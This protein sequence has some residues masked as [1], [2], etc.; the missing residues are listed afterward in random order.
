MRADIVPARRKPV[1]NSQQQGQALMLETRRNQRCAAAWGRSSGK[2]A[3]EPPGGQMSRGRILVARD[4]GRR[5]AIRSS[6]AQPD[7]VG[8][9]SV[10]EHAM[11]PVGEAAPGADLGPAGKSGPCGKGQ[12]YGRFEDH[13]RRVDA[14]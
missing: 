14:G 5:S 4:D 11:Q 2:A 8:A 6:C 13:H 9:A 3:I 12:G 1:E 10:A 7:M